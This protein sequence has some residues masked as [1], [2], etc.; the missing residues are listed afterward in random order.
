LGNTEE[1]VNKI[2]ADLASGKTREEICLALLNSGVKL[3]EINLAF[4]AAKAGTTPLYGAQVP[5][6]SQMDV[7][8]PIA[9]VAGTAPPGQ[10]SSGSAAP[11][12]GAYSNDLSPITLGKGPEAM[13]MG[14]TREESSRKVIKILVTIGAVLVGLGIFSFIASNWQKMEKTAKIAVIMVSMLSVYSGGWFLREKGGYRRSG[15]ALILLGAIIYGSGIFLIGQIFNIRSNWPDAFLLW[16]IGVVVMGFAAGS[17]SLFYLSIPIWI[18]GIFTCP[19]GILGAISDYDPFMMTSTLL[20]FA[21]FA[22]NFCAAFFI[23][24]KAPDDVKDIF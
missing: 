16:G 13:P 12:V 19:F 22:V 1:L 2:K 15:E 20:I 8:L 4:E 6:H 14:G 17:F 11:G 21:A 3:D 9:Q 5:F 10:R 7:P 18:L 23:R 24:K